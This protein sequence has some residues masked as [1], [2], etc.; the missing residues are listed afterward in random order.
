MVV[1]ENKRKLVLNTKRHA[2]VMACIPH[3]KTFSHAGQLLTALPH[4]VE[5][6]LVLKNMGFK[7]VPAPVLHYYDWP[8]RVKPMSHQTDTA[9]FLVSNRKALCLNSPGTGKSLSTLWAADYLL[10]EGVISR[11][12]IVAP[13]STLKPVWGKELAHHFM[14]RRFSI[15]TGSRVSREEKL[16]DPNIEFAI[17]NHDGFSTMPGSFKNFDLVIYD[18]AT[19][20]KN[21]SSQ[22]FKKFMHFMNEHNPWLW[23][24]TG[25]PIAQNPTDAWTLAKLV[26]SK[27]V[28]RSF[29]T[30][31]DL[32]MQK[33]TQFKWI[34]RPNALDVCKAVLQPSIRYDLSECKDLPETVHIDRQCSLTK[35]QADAYKEMKDDAC[36]IG[37]DISAANAAVLFQ[38]LVQICC[39]VALD[40]EGGQVRFD[41]TDR[42]DTLKEI[43]EEI[44]DKAIVFVP[45]RGVQTRLQ[46]YLQSVGI[47][48]AMVNGDV[49]KKD[50][51]DIFNRFQNTEEIQVLL[52]HP[53]VAAHGLT[54]TRA[55][56]I[57][58]YAPIYSLEM[59]EQANAR[60]R[61]LTTKGKTVVYHIYATVFEQEL[62]R[63]LKQKQKVLTNFLDLIKG[64]NE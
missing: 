1:V 48:V 58:W 45:L 20:L 26:G 17:I 33:L 34:P 7:N 30:F 29:T 60:I 15:I 32:V 31:K 41:D 16:E 9:A 38:K 11:V 52:A 49:S 56:S 13:L 4:G 43:L 25:T 28:P 27:T 14:H 35:E 5:E 44:G 57:I 23:M 2:E 24:L 62:Y 3:A 63:R 40:S 51:D 39:G 61:R 54:L 47:D 53:K 36:I 55:S 42:I 12:L 21:P 50:R 18:E 46:E 64:R 37:A 6:T 8:G 59:Y 22:R 19:A 10:G